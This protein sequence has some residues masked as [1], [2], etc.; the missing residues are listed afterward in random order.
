MFEE[1]LVES[2]TAPISAT[3]RWTT[4]GS[5]AFQSLI[6]A[7]LISLPLVHPERLAPHIE[8]P[9]LF[10]P[11]PPRPVVHIQPAA[12]AANASRAVLP[13]AAA[14]SSIGQLRGQFNV[15]QD[16]GPEPVVSIGGSGL[17]AGL[18]D[19]IVAGNIAAVAVVPAKPNKLVNVSEGVSA[20]MLLA[21]IQPIYPPLARNAHVAGTVVVEAV[22]SRTGTIESLRVT[23]GPALLRQS[24]VDAIRVARYQPYRLNGTPV[25]VQTTITVNFRLGS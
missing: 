12:A 24:A 7:A 2:L 25:D 16:A 9:H 11:I 19:A 3:K 5:I 15:S 8:P 17:G 1:S 18:P 22:I 13:T 10:V 23:S 4:I 6:A 14:S 21:P 20:G